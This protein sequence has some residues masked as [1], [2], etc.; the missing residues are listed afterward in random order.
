MAGYTRRTK[1][2]GVR[3][4]RPARTPSPC[5]HSR[6]HNGQTAGSRRG[7][8]LRGRRR[9]GWTRGLAD[10]APRRRARP[11]PSAHLETL[12]PGPPPTWRPFI[13][14]LFHLETLHTSP[15]P[16]CRPYAQALCP[17]L[18]ALRVLPRALQRRQLGHERAGAGRQRRA[19][20]I[21]PWRQGRRAARQAL[22]SS[23]SLGA[24]RCAHLALALLRGAAILSGAAGGARSLAARERLA[25]NF[26]QAGRPLEAASPKAQRA[27]DP[28]EAL[29]GAC[30]SAAAQHMAAAA[31]LPAV[32]AVHAQAQPQDAPA[33][34]RRPS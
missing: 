21:G 31:V 20:V 8:E 9:Q 10:G 32:P 25:T 7:A 17:H 13:Q 26:F 18:E 11:R 30:T 27:G 3:A 15:L 5:S 6:T 29:R 19:G 12:R 1:V 22:R 34:T 23:R 16:T 2:S 33:R 4:R 24:E 28:S 14:A